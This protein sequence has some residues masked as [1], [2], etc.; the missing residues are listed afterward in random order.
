MRRG[1]V[2]VVAVLAA[3][4]LQASVLDRLPFPGGSPP[5]L[6][7][8]VV[9]TLALASSPLEGAVLGFCAGL[10]T[11]VAPPAS[12]LLGLNALVFCLV[13]Y[14]C[15]RMRGPLERS[16]WLPLG[17]IAIG[18]FAG[19]SLYALAGMVFGDPDIT[20]R[21]AQYVVPVT[22]V[23]DILL[24]PFVLAGIAFLSGTAKGVAPADLLTGRDL[25]PAW[26]G[27]APAFGSVRDT[28][29]GRTPRLKLGG[30]GLTAQPHAA[31]NAGGARRPQSAKLRLRG[32]VAGSAA[33]G[34]AGRVAS[35][36]APAV[37]LHLAASRNRG[38]LTG[39]SARPMGGTALQAAFSTAGTGPRPGA[40][41]RLPGKTFSRGAPRV[42]STGPKPGAAN[43]LPGRTFS[44]GAPRV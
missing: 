12:H 7:L 1:V 31:G 32:G 4:L 39:G 41:N 9:V 38:G 26:G 22:V 6:V 43:R 44:R 23:Y 27:L 20:W 37:N 14:A 30:G 10:A 33:G 21:S 35:R 28:K 13:G 2:A 25:A 15:G 19:E 40:A 16:A 17:G 11:D 34:M 18:V 24:S 36:P 8:L 29:S 3:I 5:D 42:V